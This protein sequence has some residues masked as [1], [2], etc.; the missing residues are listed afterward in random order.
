MKSA[1]YLRPYA[2]I[3]LQIHALLILFSLHALVNGATIQRDKDTEKASESSKNPEDIYNMGSDI[4][5]EDEDSSKSGRHEVKKRSP[6]VI[7]TVAKKIATGIGRTIFKFGKSFGTI[8]PPVTTI[9]AIGFKATGL[10]TGL[11]V[12]ALAKMFRIVF[13]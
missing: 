12:K 1:W 8:L 5:V 9:P 10:G 4:P 2:F 11:G 6:Q 13:R 7:T 3:S